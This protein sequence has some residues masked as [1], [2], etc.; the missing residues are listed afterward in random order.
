MTRN[1]DARNL[2]G[3]RRV[4]RYAVPRWMIE[5]ATERRLAGDWR[6]A[7]DHVMTPRWGSP[8]NGCGSSSALPGE[9]ALSALGGEVTGCFAAVRAW[10]EGR[11]V[12]PA[13]L[14]RALLDAGARPV[15]G[16]S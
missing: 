8:R 14:V 12:V 7:C 1:G 11:N 15:T 13:E 4:R 6:G 16:R 3:W 10:T 2:A 9:Q 5:Q